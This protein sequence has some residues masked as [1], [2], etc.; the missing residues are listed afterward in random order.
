MEIVE[1]NKS[2]GMRIFDAALW[3]SLALTSL[4]VFGSFGVVMYLAVTGWEYQDPLVQSVVTV[5]KASMAL[6]QIVMAAGI[7][8]VVILKVETNRIRESNMERLEELEASIVSLKSRQGR[9]ETRP[10]RKIGASLLD[11][12]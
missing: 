1:D 6:G 11:Y 5:T 8:R 4:A 12:A 10:V 2:L 3:T 9:T 7:V